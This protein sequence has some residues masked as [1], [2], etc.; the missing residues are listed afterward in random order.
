VA[1]VPLT[2]QVALGFDYGTR[3]IGIAAGD[4]LTDGA[5]PLGVIDA[6]QGE[7]DWRQLERYL[8]EW[9]PTILIVGVPYNMDGSAG[10][11]TPAALRFADALGMRSGIEVVM[12]DERLSSREAED[13]LRQRRASGERSRRVRHRDVDAAAACVLLEQWLRGR[14]RQS[15]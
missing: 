14:T 5:R 12:V 8:R 11:I 13:L 2:P 1:R 15:E 10:P 7:P 6:H 4:T 9:A 3:R